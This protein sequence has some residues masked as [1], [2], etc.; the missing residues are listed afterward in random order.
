MFGLQK[1]TPQQPTGNA[2]MR[3]QPDNNHSA[4]GKRSTMARAMSNTMGDVAGWVMP[5]A[6][7]GLVLV[8]LLFV[9]TWVISQAILQFYE[10]HRYWLVVCLS[11]LVGIILISAGRLI[12][13]LSGVAVQIGKS[14]SGLIK[15]ADDRNWDKGFVIGRL[16]LLGA[17]FAM[18]VI[19]S[20]FAASMIGGLATYVTSQTTSQNLFA[21]DSEQMLRKGGYEVN[22]EDAQNRSL[23]VLPQMAAG[24]AISG[25]NKTGIKP[26][27]KPVIAPDNAITY[28]VKKGDT[29]NKV[30]KAHHTTTAA[31]VKANNLN[32][33]TLQI[34][35]TL[36][37]PK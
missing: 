35:Q 20:L 28:T 8:I 32:K 1:N 15:A 36:F 33:R 31:I 19:S 12:W 21:F 5:P 3:Q 27:Q 30:A 17:V 6:I 34:G 13:G 22:E 26:A 4:V 7:T 10:I 9:A 18:L 14:L 37:I 29:L 23:S 24:R 11:I 2:P 16:S 25:M